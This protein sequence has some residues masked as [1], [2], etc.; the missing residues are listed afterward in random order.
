V[1]FLDANVILRAL[2]PAID[3]VSLERAELARQ[4]LRKAERG[5]VEVTTSDAVLA[6]IAFILTSRVHY[7][8]PVVDA[9]GWINSIVQLEGFRH[10]DRRVIVQALEHWARSP[11]LGFVDALTAAYAQ[12]PGIE[13]ATFDSDFDRIPGITRWDPSEMM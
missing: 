12:S 7:Q 4:L 8:I 3:P 11:G 6:E 2:A 13:L 1:I 10:R 5:D 9:A